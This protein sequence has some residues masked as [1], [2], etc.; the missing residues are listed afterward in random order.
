[1]PGTDFVDIKMDQIRIITALPLIKQA[2]VELPLTKQQQP[3][4]DQVLME[5]GAQATMAGRRQAF[6]E[7]Q[8]GHGIEAGIVQAVH[9]GIGMAAVEQQDCLCEGFTRSV[10]AILDE[11]AGSQGS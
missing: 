5:E 4:S 9:P 1:M 7:E 6:G 8:G 2:I 11:E 10:E 3:W